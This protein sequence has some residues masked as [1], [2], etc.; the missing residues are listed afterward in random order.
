M[1]LNVKG[2]KCILDL[3]SQSKDLTTFVYVSTAFTACYT[4]RLEEK[5][6][7]PVASVYD[8]L[9]LL[10]MSEKDVFN[11]EIYSQMKGPHPNSYTFTKSLSE[12]LVNDWC[13]EREANN[14]RFIATAI[15]KPAIIMSPLHEPI[16]A[17]VEGLSQGTPA[18]GAS[19]G[20]GIN[21]MMPGKLSNHFPGIPV[22]T[23]VN[24][25]LIAAA[26]VTVSSNKSKGARASPAIYGIYNTSC[27]TITLDTA[28][29]S[30]NTSAKQTP[31]IRALRPVSMVTFSD[32]H[33]SLMYKMQV[34]IFEILF[35]LFM[36]IIL[37]LSGGK[38]M[39]HHFVVKSHKT[40]DLLSFFLCTDWKVSGCNVTRAHAKLSPEEQKIFNTRL[41]KVDWV[42][43]FTQYWIGIRRWALKEDMSNLEEA[44]KRMNR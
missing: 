24:S 18:V 2:T 32:K 3:C 38:A 7:T 42:N 35:A 23:V 21:R 16:D 4:S 12:S 9:K 37:R 5:L 40:V 10:E 17:Y 6:Y 31:S 1:T 41:D 14:S 29:T 15:G 25:L 19:M 13:K 33:T 22:D 39:V 11:R 36:D 26:D 27:N 44:K 20:L 8:M 34:F 30:A 43:F 28:F